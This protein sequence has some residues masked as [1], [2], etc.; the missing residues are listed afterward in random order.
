MIVCATLIWLMYFMHSD[1]GLHWCFASWILMLYPIAGFCSIVG[2]SILSAIDVP[3]FSYGW[4]YMVC[5]SSGSFVML[6]TIAGC[7]GVCK[8]RADESGDQS[9]IKLLRRLRIVPTCY[10]V[11]VEDIRY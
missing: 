2:C 3:E 6:Q 10:K 7:Y 8:K 9:A 11:D 5:L 1:D 4:S